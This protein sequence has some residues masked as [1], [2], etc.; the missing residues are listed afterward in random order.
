MFSYNLSVEFLLKDL[1]NVTF[2]II[3]LYC[4]QKKKIPQINIACTF[5][6]ALESES[7]VTYCIRKETL[8]QV[9]QVGKT[10]FNSIQE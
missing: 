4:L 8:K 7:E 1:K 5:L 2:Q 10:A 6:I 3:V 9:F